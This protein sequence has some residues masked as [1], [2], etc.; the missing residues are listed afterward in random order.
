MNLKQI[1]HVCGLDSSGN[2]KSKEI[3]V[4]EAI[5]PTWSEAQ[6]TLSYVRVQHCNKSSLVSFYSFFF[7]HPHTVRTS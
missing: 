6:R 5:T 1:G 4:Q 3:A 7:L 2:E